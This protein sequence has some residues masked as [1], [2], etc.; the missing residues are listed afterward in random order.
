[1]SSW[2]SAADWWLDQIADD[3]IFDTDV[4]PL[5]GSMAGDRTGL[6]LDVG[7]G[8]GRL[9][10]TLPGKWISCD[11]S[12]P[13]LRIV[14]SVNRP[15]R[16]RLPDLSWLASGTIDGAIAVLVMEHISDLDDLFNQIHRVVVPLGLLAVVMNHPAFTA[17]AA[18]PIVDV[19]DGEVL[20]R[21][22]EY[23]TEH[24]VVVDGSGGIVFHHRPLD[25]VLNA[26]AGAGWRLVEVEERGLSAQAVQ[27]H[28]GYAGQ[29][30]VPRLLGLRWSR[31]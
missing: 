29:E 27:H 18:G 10:E 6:W 16:C 2:E 8:S 11:V 13:L 12:E 1:M 7:C 21:W 25:R 26:A 20:W 14:G 28:P 31:D 19:D 15:V 30:A 24:D 9:T 23:F 3:T 4:V 5:A 22:G 17:A